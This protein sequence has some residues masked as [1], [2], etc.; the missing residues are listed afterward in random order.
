LVGIA[1]MPLDPVLLFCSLLWAAFLMVG[2]AAALASSPE[3]RAIEMPVG[4]I[5]PFSKRALQNDC[6]RIMMF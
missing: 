4:H 5:I 2:T 3:K 6:G 1:G